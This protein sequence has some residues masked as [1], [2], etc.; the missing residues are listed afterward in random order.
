MTA[1]IQ[2]NLSSPEKKQLVLAIYHLYWMAA[3]AWN[4]NGAHHKV[5]QVAVKTIVL[6]SRVL[7]IIKH[8]TVSGPFL[9]KNNE[10]WGRRFNISGLELHRTPFILDSL[11]SIYKFFADNNAIPQIRFYKGQVQ[12]TVSN[13]SQTDSI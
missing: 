9:L 1:K 4:P 12:R 11:F 10:N 2:G 7:K 3:N 6:Q 5:A 8:W 13:K